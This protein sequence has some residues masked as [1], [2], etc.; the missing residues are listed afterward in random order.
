MKNLYVTHIL[1]RDRIK[2]WLDE[3]GIK[4][5]FCWDYDI[6]QKNPE[7]N[8]SES[9]IIPLNQEIENRAI[10]LATDADY[11]TISDIV[12][13]AA[14][15]KEYGEYPP[16]LLKLPYFKL[17]DKPNFADEFTLI[18]SFNNTNIVKLGP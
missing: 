1:M 2:Q 11:Q 12:N 4:Y 15:G 17:K 10:F 8:N 5:Q 6:K 16:V 13:G 18:S 7:D 3:A 14:R 9:V